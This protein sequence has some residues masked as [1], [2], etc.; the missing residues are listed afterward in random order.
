MFS[1]FNIAD[2]FLAKASMSPKKLQRLVYYA[3]AWTLALLNETIDDLHFHLFH[4]RIEAWV[5][6]PVVPDLYQQY[7]HYGWKDIPQLNAYSGPTFPADVEDVLNQVWDIYGILSASE[8]E[9][10]SHQES[11]WINT[12]NRKHPCAVS[13]DQISDKDLFS[14]FNEQANNTKNICE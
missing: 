14:F 9:M 6:G 2:F 13:S 8:L 1:V 11:P 4:N 10:I 12:R 3:Y 5:H 7:K